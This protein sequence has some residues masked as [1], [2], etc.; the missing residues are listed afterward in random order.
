MNEKILVKGEF[1]NTNPVS[2]L[3]FIIAGLAFVACFIVATIFG[4][5]PMWAFKGM[6]YGYYWFFIGIAVFVLLGIK[7]SSVSMK[8]ELI[9]TDGRVIG[10]T[11]FGKRVDLPISQVSVVGT[12]SMNRVSI[13][14]SSGAINFYSVINQNQVATEI[15]QLLL[16]RQ[17][18]T[19]TGTKASGNLADELKNLKE[20]LDQ[21]VITQDEF[22]AKKK[23]LLD[24]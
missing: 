9:V 12:G 3:C 21:G 2:L 24:L 18:E 23:Q 14:T 5:S 16:K 7:F 6:S 1:S 4:G 8:P 10:K 20:L 13:A 15:S 17:E 22:D 11:L 19:K